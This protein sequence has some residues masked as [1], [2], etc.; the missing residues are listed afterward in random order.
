MQMV[1]A[2]EINP[3]PS[4]TIPT[5]GLIPTATVLVTTQTPSMTTTR[6]QPTVMV[7]DM[8]T[9]LL[10]TTLMRSRTMQTNGLTATTMA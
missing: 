10:G 2:T 6:K 9:T 3:T 1:M 5:S 7:T 8:V 4:Q